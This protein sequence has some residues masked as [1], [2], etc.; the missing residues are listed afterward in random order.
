MW[1]N[2][3]GWMIIYFIIGFGTFAFISWIFSFLML[4]LDENSFIWKL[5]KWSIDNRGCFLILILCIICFL[6]FL[7]L[8]VLCFRIY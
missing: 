5:C 8:L 3:I 4:G 1:Y 2:I 7:D 6:L